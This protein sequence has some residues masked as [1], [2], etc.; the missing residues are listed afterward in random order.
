MCFDVETETEGAQMPELPQC[1]I[2]L[3]YFYAQII[4]LAGRISFCHLASCLDAADLK[5]FYQVAE[6][7]VPTCFN[8]CVFT[9]AR[10][11]LAPLFPNATYICFT[12]LF[13]C[14]TLLPLIINPTI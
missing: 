10:Y 6:F 7:E 2:D 9:T 1:H 4:I 13:D 5:I 8:V 11:L 12:I 14:K 3:S